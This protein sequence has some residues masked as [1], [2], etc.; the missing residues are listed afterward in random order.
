M[1]VDYN[2]YGDRWRKMKPKYL[3]RVILTNSSKSAP[4]EPNKDSE[5]KGIWY[6]GR[7]GHENRRLKG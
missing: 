5:A 3:Q 4:T 2:V 6:K 1:K 7:H